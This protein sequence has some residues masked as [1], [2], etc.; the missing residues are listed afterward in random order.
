[1][2][3]YSV[4]GYRDDRL[5]TT[6]HRCVAGNP[7]LPTAGREGPSHLWAAASERPNKGMC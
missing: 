2:Y 4:F 1:M 5:L 7:V 3:A 6:Y